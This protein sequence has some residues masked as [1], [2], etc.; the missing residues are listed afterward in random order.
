M[1]SQT[2]ER[3]TEMCSYPLP[4][5][6]PGLMPR[7]IVARA[8]IMIPQLRAL[9][10]EADQRGHFS[11]QTLRM[12][13]DAGFYRILQPVMFG[14]YDFDIGTYFEVVTR[15]ARG[16][17]ATAW[18]FCL[19]SSQGPLVAAHFPEDAQKEL[20]GPNGDFR[21]PFRAVP[22]GKIEPVPGGYRVTGR[23]SY[24]SGVPVSN[25]YAANS[26]LFVNGKPQIM[27]FFIPIE[28]VSIVDDWGGDLNLGMQASGSNSVV[29]DNVFVPESRVRSGDFHFGTDI[30]FD[31]GTIGT[32]L[33]GNPFYLGIFAGIYHCCFTAIM[34][35]TAQAAMD[36]FQTLVRE[37]KAMGQPGKMMIDDPD[38]L[39]ATGQAAVKIDAAEAIMHE[40]VLKSSA[41]FDR[42][43]ASKAPIT[44]QETMPIWALGRAGALLAAEAVDILFRHGTPAVARKGHRMQRYW[45]DTQMYLVHPAS[46]SWVE[47]ARGEAALNLPISRYQK[48]S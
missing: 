8:Q 40:A 15:I 36:E 34:L 25:H 27:T 21:S 13:M 39:R 16:H 19:S 23:W 2:I 33:H 47:T 31:K 42:W 24:S 9:Q 41:L 30:D 3:K 18:C 6:E 12:F 20:F 5:P 45:R 29:V 28:E 1:S 35:G 26:M 44:P 4:Q 32:E 46:Q 48:A 17:P 22:S 37:T 10:D 11:E 7:D 43:K 14:G 38:I